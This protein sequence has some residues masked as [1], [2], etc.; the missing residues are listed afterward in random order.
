[1]KGRPQ[2]VFCKDKICPQCGVSFNRTVNPLLKRV[3]ESEAHFLK[4]RF[5]G[6]KCA[7]ASQRAQMSEK[8]KR[9][10]DLRNAARNRRAVNDDDVVIEYIDPALANYTKLVEAVIGKHPVSYGFI[11]RALG[12]EARRDLTPIAIH[13]LEAQ[14]K[15]FVIRG[16]YDKFSTEPQESNWFGELDQFGKR[17]FKGSRWVHRS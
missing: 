1:M 2:T 16:L 11:H 8:A 13:D 4:R 15:V 14:G 12:Q 6:V 9:A 5:C 17:V 7:N 10:N 3:T